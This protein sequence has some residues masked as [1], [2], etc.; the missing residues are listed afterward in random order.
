MAGL[1]VAPSYT[2]AI[3]QQWFNLASPGPYFTGPERLSMAEIIREPADA[4]GEPSGLALEAALKIAHRAATICPKW[5]D[6]IEHFGLPRGPYVEVVS[7]VSRVT[8]VDRFVA[9]VGAKLLPLPTALEGSPTGDIELAARQRSAYVPILEPAAA[10]TALSLLPTEAS[11]RRQLHA[12]FYLDDDDM[13]DP[14]SGRELTRP[15]M[16]LLA[17]R[18]SFNNG[19]AYSL[20][21]H[22][23]MLRAS[24]D[25]VVE[26]VDLRAVTDPSVDSLIRDGDVLLPFADAV[27]G[28]G[29]LD[30]TRQALV[31]RV[32]EAATVRAAAVISTFEMMN[33]VLDATGIPIPNRIRSIAPELGLRDGL[34]PTV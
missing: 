19:C 34:L 32:G 27:A 25:R 13:G 14:D 15:Q 16:E 7:V 2:E 20:F 10:S 9:A 5:L 4:A 18:T 21:A 8:A 22:S 23:A 6:E 1:D 24:I 30:A 17:A 26:R 11:A 29:D 28:Q 31:D 33:R 3:G 12:A